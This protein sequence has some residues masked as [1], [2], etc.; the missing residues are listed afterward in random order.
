MQDDAKDIFTLYFG[1]NNP[2]KVNEIL[3]ILPPTFRLLT[4]KDVINPPDPEETG[5]I[6]EANAILK[7]IAYHQAT[8][9]IAFADDTGL[10]VEALNGAPG[11]YTAR[12][13]GPNA[14]YVTNYTK[15]LQVMEGIEN[16]KARFRTVIALAGWKG[17]ATPILFEGI[18][19]GYISNEPH[20]ANGFGYDPVFVFPEKNLTLAELSEQEKNQISH[21]KRALDKFVAFLESENK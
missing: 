15:L 12:Y 3:A 7:A 9:L 13:A 11:V 14:D 4:P 1:S 20:G 8:D 21:R 6:L 16:R 5:T 17:M 18:L 19:E 10:E 2:H